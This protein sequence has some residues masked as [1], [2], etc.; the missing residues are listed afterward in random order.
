[1]LP[2]SLVQPA[3]LRT[4]AR[5]SFGPHVHVPNEA[6]MI[7]TSNSQRQSRQDSREVAFFFRGLQAAA[8][9]FFQGRLGR[10]PESLQ[11][12]HQFALASSSSVFVFRLSYFLP[13]HYNQSSSAQEQPPP[14][15]SP[16]RDSYTSHLHYETVSVGPTMTGIRVNL[17]YQLPERLLIV[18]PPLSRLIPALVLL[19]P[20]APSTETSRCCKV[21]LIS[22]R[23]SNTHE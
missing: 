11:S 9:F 15:Q 14:R 22:A 7:H 13:L 16:S 19:C 17:A 2:L 21:S 10:E 18:T 6:A 1:M 4:Q 12:I 5:F 8:F 3:A 23:R 20:L